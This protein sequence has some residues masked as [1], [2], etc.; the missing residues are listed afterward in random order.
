MSFCVVIQCIKVYNGNKVLLGGKM[1]KE[2]VL[3][4]AISDIQESIRFLDTKI[5]F[6][7]GVIGIIFAGLVGCK[8]NFYTVYISVSSNGKLLYLV[9]IAAILIYLISTAGVFFFAVRCML[10]KNNSNKD[11]SSIWFLNK[12]IDFAVY[13][14][15]ID[16]LKESNIIGLLARE[17]YNVNII[18]LRKFQEVKRAF[19]AFA[20]SCISL[21]ILSLFLVLYYL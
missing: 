20:V 3:L 9:Y 13:K 4:A 14:H 2:D 17:L 12:N 21:V 6:I 11:N 18:N 8:D 7:L 10:P 16:T 15:N 1:C 5:T 19:Q